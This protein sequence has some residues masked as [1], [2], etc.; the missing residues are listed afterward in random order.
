[1]SRNRTPLT[2]LT[3]TKFDSAF[4]PRRHRAPP[5]CETEI[6]DSF[7]NGKLTEL[8]ICNHAFRHIERFVL[9]TKEKWLK[10]YEAINST[11]PILS[12]N[13]LDIEV[14]E[15]NGVDD[16]VLH[17]VLGNIE[18]ELLMKAADRHEC[19]LWKSVFDKIHYED[20]D[21]DDRAIERHTRPRSRSIEKKEPGMSLGSHSKTLPNLGKRK[22][23]AKEHKEA[24]SKT[25][26]IGNNT[27]A[28]DS[29]SIH[30]KRGSNAISS[31]IRSFTIDTLGR[32]SKNKSYELP[33]DT[34][35]EEDIVLKETQHGM[36]KQ[37]IEKD[38]VEVYE[39][40]FCR[41][42]GKVFQCYIQ[43]SDTKPLFKVPL[44]NAAIQDFANPG[45][46][47]YRFVITALDTGIEYTFALDNER[48]LDT[49][50]AALFGDDQ[51]HKSLE[52][53]PQVPRRVSTS[54][55]YT[56]TSPVSK[57]TSI[58]STRT[59][60]G[61]KDSFAE[62]EEEVSTTHDEGIRMPRRSTEPFLMVDKNDALD[63]NIEIVPEL[64]EEEEEDVDIGIV[65]V[66]SH[67]GP[68]TKTNNIE[69]RNE[70]DMSV[71]KVRLKPVTDE[72]IKHSSVMFEVSRSDMSR[73]KTKRWVVLR[74]T[75]MELY[76]NEQDKYPIKILY[77]TK[78]ELIEIDG[79]SGKDSLKITL[80]CEED[81]SELTLIASD[82]NVRKIWMEEIK[83]LCRSLKRRKNPR[84]SVG[85]IM[86]RLGSAERMK[87]LKT[88]KDKRISMLLVDDDVKAIEKFE[89]TADPAKMMSGNCLV[90]T[91]T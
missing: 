14:K 73:T 12:F 90:C 22:K 35:R 75:V 47:L 83:K 3:P 56:P 52:N 25:K 72:A 67:D 71:K 18:V 21:D 5:W 39:E 20:V 1:M 13:A 28:S 46:A 54:T 68:I 89:E 66:T 45:T 34:V 76:N 60:V 51:L 53:S 31:L 7:I 50:T 64:R 2:P 38:G 33:K 48:D 63:K 36:I 29:P 11:T 9:I 78:Y 82:E 15:E 23:A 55:F 58:A 41:I 24:L 19:N 79:A 86:R 37:V 49:W 8:Q 30:R 61:S 16:Q 69:E 32:K 65:E 87:E 43:E 59:S 10:V 26:S 4:Q 42:R 80:R 74:K 88:K 27:A 77:L 85:N 84:H 40:K 6:E 70:K 62:D 44:K 57:R 91:C 17:L 81:D